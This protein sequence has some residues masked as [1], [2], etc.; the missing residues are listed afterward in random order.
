LEFSCSVIEYGR[1][2]CQ[3]N[4]DESRTFQS[5]SWVV[6]FTLTTWRWS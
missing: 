6:T 5:G 4:A 3:M 2:D 1:P